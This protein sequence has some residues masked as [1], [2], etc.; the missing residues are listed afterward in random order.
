VRCLNRPHENSAESL[1]F[2]PARCFLRLLAQHV[3]PFARLSY[4]LRVIPRQPGLV[5]PTLQRDEQTEIFIPHRSPSLLRGK[6]PPSKLYHATW[7]YSP[8]PTCLGNN[9]GYSRH[10]IVPWG[11]EG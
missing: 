3:L 11:V 1:V 8:L 4:W 2:S 9:L 7:G 5:V 10:D 6:H